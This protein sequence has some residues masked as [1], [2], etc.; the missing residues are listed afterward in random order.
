MDLVLE[1]HFKCPTNDLFVCKPY[2][3]I[4]HSLLRIIY[5]LKHNF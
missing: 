4:E 1:A 5:L 3:R 2:I